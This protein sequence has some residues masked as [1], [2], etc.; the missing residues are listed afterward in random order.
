MKKYALITD[1]GV[2]DAVVLAEIK[3][4]F[5][6]YKYIVETSV[7]HTGW[8]YS[9]GKFFEPVYVKPPEKPISQLEFLRRFTA[10]ERVKIR[11]SVDDYVVDFLHLL[12]LAQEISVNDPDTIAGVNYLERV[13]LLGQ[14]RAQEILSGYVSNKPPEE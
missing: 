5:K 14:G 11:L 1:Q 7:A 12:N 3:P 10:D 9:N 13:Q 6:Q 8:T 4:D 2:V